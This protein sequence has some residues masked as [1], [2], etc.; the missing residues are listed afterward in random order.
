MI[1]MT[2]VWMR[3]TVTTK[4]GNYD[5]S[6][7]ESDAEGTTVMTKVK[8]VETMITVTTKGPPLPART[9]VTTKVKVVGTMMK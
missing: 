8:V 1:V 2:M 3:T 4:G 9:T 5:D 6:E 7:D